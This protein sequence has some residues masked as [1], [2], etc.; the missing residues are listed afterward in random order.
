MERKRFFNFGRKK[1]E[2]PKEV[3]PEFADQYLLDH[4]Q[5][6]ILGA[7]TTDWITIFVEDPQNPNQFFLRKLKAKETTVSM[8]PD[9][10]MPGATIEQLDLGDISLRPAPKAQFAK[11]VEE[12]RTSERMLAQDPDPKM[13]EFS[14]VVAVAKYSGSKPMTIDE[15]A[16]V[17][18]FKYF[19]LKHSG[20][21]LETP[22]EN[23]VQAMI[24]NIVEVSSADF[25][26]T[27]KKGNPT[28]DSL[29][30][31]IAKAPQNAKIRI[32][33]VVDKDIKNDVE[34]S[35]AI[36]EL[37]N[38]SDK[39]GNLEIKVADSEKAKEVMDNSEEQ[40]N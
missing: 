14:A 35:M 7:P 22:G 21:P 20:E 10:N 3:K 1:E 32:I 23:M 27:A 13:R 19:L 29:P 34:T 6:K 9:L 38:I 18:A 31:I 30:D 16:D 4:T 26:I 11:I 8:T 36:G 33:L 40:E 5:I 24:E 12:I 37:L 17:T 25:I 2:K 28:F 39:R 15:I